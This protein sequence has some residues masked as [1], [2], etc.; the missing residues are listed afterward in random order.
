MLNTPRL[1]RT[2]SAALFA[3]AL[4]GV[5]LVAQG[6]PTAAAS[7]VGNLT[8]DAIGETPTPVFAVN[9]GVTNTITDP[10]G[11]GGGTG[12]AT[13]SGFTISRQTDGLS[14]LLFRAAA[15]GQHIKDVQIDVFRQGGNGIDSSYILS[16]VLVTSFSTD[17]LLEKV[18]F[19]YTKI[20]V[21]SGG[22]RTCW[23]LATNASC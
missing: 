11:G 20:E 7:P 3:A 16:D 2:I 17:A 4:T 10:T 14:P 1:T 22:V 6:P 12:K 19:T 23:N 13:F 18:T 9:F 21:L 15:T 5:T 8:V